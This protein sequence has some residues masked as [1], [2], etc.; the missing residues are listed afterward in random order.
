MRILTVVVVAIVLAACGPERPDTLGLVPPTTI[1]F[2]EASQ[3]KQLAVEAELRRAKFKGAVD[4]QW[5]SSNA[6]V[7]TVSDKGLVQAVGSGV[8]TITATTTGKGE[9]PISAKVEVRASMV[10]SLAI[11][12]DPPPAK[13]TT[14]V[15]MKFNGPAATVLASITDEKG[16][17]LS[18]P[19]IKWRASDYCVEVE[20]DGVKV[21][22]KPLAIGECKVIASSGTKSASIAFEVK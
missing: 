15:V 10:G 17:P 5:S 6:A 20:G 22:V 2:E 11:A 9:Q 4:V 14:P 7:A 16:T 21:Q 18:K 12:L 3:S 19:N 1:M 13:P 8:A